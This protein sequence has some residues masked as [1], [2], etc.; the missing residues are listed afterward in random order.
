MVGTSRG[1]YDTHG[2]GWQASKATVKER[3]SHLFQR[4][5]MADVYFIVGNEA[6]EQTQV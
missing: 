6:D 2:L 5:T 1:D 3:M 4:E